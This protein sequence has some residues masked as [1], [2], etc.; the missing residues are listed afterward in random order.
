MPLPDLILHRRAYPTLWQWR[1]LTCFLQWNDATNLRSGTCPYCIRG[2]AAIEM[3]TSI[4]F[5]QSD[6]R[7]KALPGIAVPSTTI[8]FNSGPPAWALLLKQLLQ[9]KQPSHLPPD[10]Q[11]LE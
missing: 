1:C 3:P 4:P 9:P 5:A 10:Y 7:A 8:S 11:A 6:G 2:I